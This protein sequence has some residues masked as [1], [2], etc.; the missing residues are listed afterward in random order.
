MRR[1]KKFFIIFLMLIFSCS[2]TGCTTMG[3]FGNTQLPR[4]ESEE[5]L[6]EFV[7]NK[8]KL[9]EKEIKAY[10]STKITEEEYTKLN[11]CIDGYY[12]KISE[13]RYRETFIRGYYRVV[14]YAE[15]SDNYYAEGIVLGTIKKSE[16]SKR[17]V[18]LADKAKQILEEIIKED[19]TDYEKELA[20]HD[21]IVSHGEYGY[22]EGNNKEQS[23]QAYGILVKNKGVCQAYAEAT[24]LLLTLSGI[25]SKIIVGTG[26]ENGE[27]HAWNLVKLD[28]GWYQLDTTW[29][30]PAPDREGRILYTYFNITDEQMEK[31]HEWNKEIYPS[32]KSEKNNYYKK[33]GI[34]FKTQAEAENY[35]RDLI[36][37]EHATVIDFMVEDYSEDKYGKEW[38]SFIWEIANIKAISYEIYGKGEKVSFRFY[39][40]YGE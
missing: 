18:E 31:D 28:D 35:I 20:I 3:V 32:A 8:L 14:M 21:Y 37:T 17:A 13:Y 39:M 33:E 10:I 16:A 24:Q 36:V 6:Y 15:I 11:E 7:Q 5:E 29:D 1:L 27:N 25:K 22:L 40:E 30:D 26:K 23:Y 9:G 34:S 38:G 2:F 4:I 12:G 19:M